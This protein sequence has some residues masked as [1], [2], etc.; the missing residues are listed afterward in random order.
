[1]L[2]WICALWRG[3]ASANGAAI[4]WDV[5][6]FELHYGSHAAILC[7]SLLQAWGLFRGHT[8]LRR[9]DQHVPMFQGMTETQQDTI[10]A[11]GRS[12]VQ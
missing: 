12:V 9:S 10:V 8:L 6:V 3:P 4:R 11:A 7:R 2:F 5:G 1:M